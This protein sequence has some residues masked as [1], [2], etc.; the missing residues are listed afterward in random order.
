LIKKAL[1]AEENA[2]DA[3][4]LNVA[5]HRS[6]N[7][8]HNSCEKIPRRFRSVGKR[9]DERLHRRTSRR[10]LVGHIQSDLRLYIVD[11]VV[12]DDR[13]AEFERECGIIRQFA[14]DS[15]VE[16]KEQ[17]TGLA[18][19][20]IAQI[21]PNIGVRIK[22]KKPSIREAQVEGR[23]KL[24]VADVSPGRIAGNARVISDDWLKNSW[25]N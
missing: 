6:E 9:I 13:H 19:D 24:Q 3:S 25:M 17:P 14:S 12:L 23:R 15:G 22:G 7:L 5:A 2:V 8:I 4:T 20:R 1:G 16:R 11:R 21:C 18:S 10:D